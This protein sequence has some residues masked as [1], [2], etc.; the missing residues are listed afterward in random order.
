MTLTRDSDNVSFVH[1]TKSAAVAAGHV[2]SDRNPIGAAA[3]GAAQE[4]K[5]KR[6]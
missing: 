4:K 6:T 3:V 1:R 5:A 2:S